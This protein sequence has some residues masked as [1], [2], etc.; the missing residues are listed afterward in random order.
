[1]PAIRQYRIDWMPI[2]S[3]THSCK[4]PQRVSQS[5]AGAL[6]AGSGQMGEP[7]KVVVWRVG[8]SPISARGT[9]RSNGT[10]S[11]LRPPVTAVIGRLAS[12]SA[13]KNREGAAISMS[14][15]QSSCPLV[16]QSM[17]GRMES[18]NKWPNSTMKPTSVQPSRKN[19]LANESCNRFPE[20]L[21]LERGV[22]EDSPS[23]RTKEVS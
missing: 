14:A 11:H 21:V 23:F 12:S 6:L 13:A 18:H 17:R 16:A 9:I 20:R 15:D 19:R 2:A 3:R 5:A 8:Q 10:H 22:Y 4:G 1:M 7:P